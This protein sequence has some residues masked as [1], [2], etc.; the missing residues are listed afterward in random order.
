MKKVVLVLIVI[1]GF[2]TQAQNIL[3]ERVTGLPVGNVGADLTGVTFGP[4]GW[5]IFAAPGTALS[6]MAVVNTL[7]DRGNAFQI[8]GSN[9][10]TNTK[11]IFNNRIGANWATRTSGNNFA[12]ISF[13]FFSGPAT[14]SKNTMRMALYDASGSRVLAGIMITMNT[15]V[16]TGL[17]N[18]NNAG[19]IGNFSFGMGASA[20]APIVLLPNTWYKFGCSFNK[21]TGDVRWRE[22]SGLFSKVIVGAAAGFDVDELDMLGTAGALNTFSSIGIFDNI[23]AKA[24]ATDEMFVTRL[25][26]AS[27]GSALPLI[28]STI[29]ANSV[30]E[31]TEYKFIVTNLTTGIAQ[32]ID[33]PLRWFNLTELANYDYATTYGVRVVLKVDGAFSGYS[34]ASANVTTEAA[35]GILT[36]SCG[37][38]LASVNTTFYTKPL[39]AV[40][41]YRFKI[42]TPGQSDVIKDSSLQFFNFNSLTTLVYNAAYTVEVAV[43]TT[44]SYTPYGSVCNFST[45]APTLATSTCG[46]TLSNS[47]VIYAKPLVG[48][49]SYL[50]LVKNLSTMTSYPVITS[51]TQ[52]F[53]ANLIPSY[54]A[55]TPYEI[56]VAVV[57]TGVTSAYGPTCVINPIPSARQNNIAFGTED[58]KISGYPNPFEN[59]FE[60][61]IT[62]SKDQT[63]SLEV[64]DIIGKLIDSKEITTFDKSI[65]IGSKYQSGVY[66]MI[67]TQGDVVK[68]IRIVKR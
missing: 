11:Y 50:F 32:S 14:T 29:F 68:S 57:S 28:T 51:A 34:G 47:G 30:P 17:A 5:K 7:G 31:A 41:G 1:L 64:Y 25:T 37:A 10:A 3:N 16:V 33:K 42:K 20:A 13:D 35:P 45:P 27:S 21:T 22:F 60:I 23:N 63:A 48:A 26:P 6:D 15:K 40:T 53:N 12:E 44:G 66:N 55:A 54:S 52:F 9:T 18:Y 19:T 2:S 4:S 59:T 24:T 58:L 61:N 43:K 56:K 67:I 65:S 38:A 49:T 62:S 46:S 36:P 39:I 8:T